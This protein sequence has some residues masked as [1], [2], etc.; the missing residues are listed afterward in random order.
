MTTPTVSQQNAQKRDWLLRNRGVLTRVS[1]ELAVSVAFAS[2]VFWGRRRSTTR[3]VEARL[4]DLGAPGF[5]DE[6]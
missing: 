4:A 3:Q 2:D 6:E 5:K 1:R